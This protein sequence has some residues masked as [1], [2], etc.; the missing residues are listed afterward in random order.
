R[1]EDGGPTSG[2]SSGQR[3]RLIGAHK[4]AAQFYAE[5]LATPGAQKAREFL[6]ERGFDQQAAEHFGVGFAPQGWDA[7]TVH[8]R[9]RGF[10][11]E[12][13]V[14]GGLSNNVQPGPP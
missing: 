9:G 6:S 8:L 10:T 13:L 4:A 3:S 12:E 5:Q 7:L 14:A 2:R 1:Y 11:Q